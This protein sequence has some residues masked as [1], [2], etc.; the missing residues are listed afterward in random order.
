MEDALA[1]AGV[2]GAEQVMGPLELR[3]WSSDM[4]K[5]KHL[6]HPKRRE[7]TLGHECAPLRK[8]RPRS[9]PRRVAPSLSVLLLS[10]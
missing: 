5:I 7:E 4:T 6:H 10:V 2:V 1:L 9:L 8:T 3:G